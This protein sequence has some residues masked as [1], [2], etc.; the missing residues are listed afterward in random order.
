[1]HDV[2]VDPDKN[3]IFITVG[4]IK[5]EAEMKTIV[6]AINS[7]CCKLKAGFTCVTDLRNYILQ[8]EKFECY[9]KDAQQ[10]LIKAGMFKVVRVHRKS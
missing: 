2:K 5:N 3:R 6:G 8:D 10:I 9:I 1:M 4:T 7:E